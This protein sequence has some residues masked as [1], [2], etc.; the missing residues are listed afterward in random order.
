M[1]LE[2]VLEVIFTIFSWKDQN[3]HFGWPAWNLPL[4]P[5][6]FGISLKFHNFLR[7]KDFSRSAI[8]QATRAVH[9]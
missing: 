6:I 9:L 3:F 5:R 1:F 8:R 4:I 7:Y 2:N